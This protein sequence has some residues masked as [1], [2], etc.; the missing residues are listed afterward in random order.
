LHY[1]EISKKKKKL[2]KNHIKLKNMAGNRKMAHFFTQ[3]GKNIPL[4]NFT[5]GSA[6]L[7]RF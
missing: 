1:S 6:F 5:I 4:K 7:R 3:M 2:Q